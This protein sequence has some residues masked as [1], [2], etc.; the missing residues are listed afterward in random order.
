MWCIADLDD[1]YIE[2][3]EDVLEVYEKPLS[4]E[5]PVVCVDEK[6]VTLHEEVRDPIPM[7]PGSVAKRDNEYERCGTANV[8]CGIEPQAG[9]H[10]TKVTPTRS[11]PEFADFIRSVA[12][13]Y[14]AA[15]TIHLVMDNLSSHTKKALTDRFGKEE[16]EALW[17]RFTVHYTPVH[18]SWLNQA[19][20]EIGL[21]SRQCL[22]KRRFGTIQI[23]RAEARAWN[24]RTNRNRTTIKWTFDRKKARRKFKY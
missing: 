8:F 12:N 18:G 3:M 10:F 5:E 11:S 1:D 6:P 4:A 14:P 7:K 23:L 9:V 16:G 21:F 13:H 2:H 15:Q 17:D 22:G 20:L 24:Q 19:E